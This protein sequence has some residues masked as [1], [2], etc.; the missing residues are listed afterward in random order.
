MSVQIIGGPGAPPPAT[1]LLSGVR[2]GFVKSGFLFLIVIDW[3]MK[4]TVESVQQE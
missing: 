2:Q 3:V 1:A 4:T